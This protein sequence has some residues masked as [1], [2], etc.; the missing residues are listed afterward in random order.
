VL[1]QRAFARYPRHPFYIGSTLSGPN[2]F[3]DCES[4]WNMNS[5]EPH[6]RYSSGG[7]YELI[8]G[9][10]VSVQNRWDNGTSH[11]WAGVN[12]TLW[13]HR[14]PFGRQLGFIISQPDISPNY[15]FGLE[16]ERRPFEYSPKNDKAL[17]KPAYEYGIG[18][19]VAPESLYLTQL[20]ERYGPMAVVNTLAGMVP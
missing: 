8:F 1:V 17:N 4:R 9:G 3:R 6:F 5:S 12:Y 13:N 20:E 2:V 18:S 11:G 16:A 14:S 7:L 15:A 19:W 10:K